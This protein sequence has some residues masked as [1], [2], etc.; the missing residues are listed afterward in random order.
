MKILTKFHGEIEINEEDIYIF[1]SG[2]PGFLEEKQFSLLTLD[3]TPF[4]V[5]QSITKPEVAFIMTNPFE[6]FSTYEVN[7]P[8][9]VLADLQIQSEQDVAVFTILSVREPFE[10]T[11][12]NLQAPIILNHTKK[13]GKQYIMKTN[14]YTTRHKLIPPL[15]A[16]KQE[17]K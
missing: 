6:L 2:I 7:L 12:A 3:E 17:V 9:E 1:E 13:L 8:D 4:F 16:T 14:N 11:T 10:K 5:L 15:V